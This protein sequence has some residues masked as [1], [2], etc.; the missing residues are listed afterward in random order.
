MNTPTK[1]TLKLLPCPFC[2]RT[3][4]PTLVNFGGVP[5]WYIRCCIVDTCNRKSEANAIEAWNTRAT[6][7]LERQRDALAEA[8][9]KM[10]SSFSA[11]GSV[12]GMPDDYYAGCECFKCEAIKSARKALAQL[13]EGGV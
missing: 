12:K 7:D 9:D 11:H 1:E 10:L 8:L 5:H 4:K 2:G 3:P 6:S 13:K